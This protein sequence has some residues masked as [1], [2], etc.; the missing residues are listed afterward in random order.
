MSDYVWSFANQET[1]RNSDLTDARNWILLPK[2]PFRGQYQV[3]AEV[4][5]HRQDEIH[6]GRRARRPVMHDVFEHN[7][8]K[9]L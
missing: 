9:A 8:Q 6:G 7:A 3:K 5:L 2:A 4:F 1:I